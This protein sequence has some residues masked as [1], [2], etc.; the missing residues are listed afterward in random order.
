MSSNSF[1]HCVT[2]QYGSRH[3]NSL[4]SIGDTLALLAIACK[5]VSVEEI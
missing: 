3:R 1:M 5:P 4:S 2:D